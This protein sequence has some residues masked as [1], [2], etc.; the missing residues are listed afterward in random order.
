MACARPVILVALLTDAVTDG[1]AP[2]MVIDVPLTASTRPVSS[3]RSCPFPL[4]LPGSPGNPVPAPPPDDAGADA[5]TDVGADTLGVAPPA[6]LAA[7]APRT[8]KNPATAPAI[9]AITA[10][11]TKTG[12]P[13]TPP[14]P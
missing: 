14:R 6:A 11:A 1:P 2:P 13:E 4:A 12:K 10:T 7:E 3:I 8:R 9:A 5:G